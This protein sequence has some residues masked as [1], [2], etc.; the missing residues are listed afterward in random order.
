MPGNNKASPN[1]FKALDE[2]H[3]KI[4]YKF[5]RNWLEDLDLEHAEWLLA[6]VK[7]LPKKG[8]LKDLNN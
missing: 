1:G 5:I 3:R 2:G 6:G 4:L 8:N 7:P